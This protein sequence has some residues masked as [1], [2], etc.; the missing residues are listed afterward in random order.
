[1]PKLKRYRR[2]L[3]TTLDYEANMIESLSTQ[4]KELGLNDAYD[5]VYQALK[6]GRIVDNMSQHRADY[7]FGSDPRRPP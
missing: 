4:V 7:F 6:S 2:R 5:K 1:M 3:W